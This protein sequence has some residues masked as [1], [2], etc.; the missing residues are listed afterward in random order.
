MT[1]SNVKKEQR[2]K[3][4]KKESKINKEEKKDQLKKG[5]QTKKKKR[6]IHQGV[7]GRDGRISKYVKKEN[8][9]RY[10]VKQVKKYTYVGIL[11]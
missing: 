7:S 5:L 1:E 8:N 10:V 9:S 2:K 6:K 4:K 11:K 3:E